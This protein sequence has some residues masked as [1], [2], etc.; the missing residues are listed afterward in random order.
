MADHARPLPTPEEWAHIRRLPLGEKIEAIVD[1]SLDVFQQVGRIET[2]AVRAERSSERCELAAVRAE[3]AAERC[4]ASAA[5]I[6][7]AVSK[8]SPSVPPMRKKYDSLIDSLPPAQ[9][10]KLARL[11]EEDDRG[12]AVYGWWKTWMMRAAFLAAFLV[13]LLTLAGLA[14]GAYLFIAKHVV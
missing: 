11:I 4:E 14:Y 6:E 12:A 3:R 2:S 9:A 1:R 5:R 7:A 8:K 13:S 10:D